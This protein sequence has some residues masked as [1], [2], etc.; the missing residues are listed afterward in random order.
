MN[1]I[2]MGP[3]GA[4]KGTQAKL[5]CEKLSIP[6]ISTGDILREVTK[7]GTEKGN[8][9]KALID[10]GNLVPDDIILDIIRERIAKDDCSG[11]F[12]LDGFP[13]TIPQAK[14]LDEMGIEINKVILIEVQDEAIIARMSKRRVCDVCGATYHLEHRKPLNEGVCDD[15]GGKLVCRKDDDPKTVKDRLS[16]YH[17]TTEPLISYY[18]QSQRLFKVDGRK[19]MEDVFNTILSGLGL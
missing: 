2:L 6:A 13:R 14:A 12:L 7:S 1:L 9:I 3:P 19:S 10:A 17:K 5:I 18:E 11:G 4:G 16:V 15:C 8:Q